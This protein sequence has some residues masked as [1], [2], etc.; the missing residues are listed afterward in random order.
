MFAQT[1]F[2]P[3][4]FFLSLSVSLSLVELEKC[5]KTHIC[6]EKSVS[7]QPRTSPPKIFNCKIVLTC[8]LS[9]DRV[10]LLREQLDLGRR[11]VAT[12]GPVLA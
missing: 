7:I 2:A 11:H 5:C 9:Q 3:L 1:S 6:L 4:S 10:L 8:L 12:A